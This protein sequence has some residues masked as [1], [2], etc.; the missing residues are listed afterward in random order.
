MQVDKVTNSNSF[1]DNIQIKPL[2]L[3]EEIK[4]SERLKSFKQ[5]HSEVINSGTLYCKNLKDI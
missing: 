4:K 1:Q 3:S 5:M 2:D